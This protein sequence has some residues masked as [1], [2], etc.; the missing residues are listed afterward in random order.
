[1]YTGSEKFW[2]KA[3]NVYEKVMTVFFVIVMLFG[4]YIT[5]DYIYIYKYSEQ[6]VKRFKP[7]VIN[8]DTLRE[9]SGDAV[10]WITLDD[11]PID[12]PIMQTD[13]NVDYLNKDPK[14]KYS[15]G[16]SIFM[17]FR[18]SS[19]FTDRYSLVYGHH[20]AAKRMFG[21][22]DMYKEKDFAESHQ[23]GI[24]YTR[25]KNYRVRVVSYYITKTDCDDI[26]NPDESVDRSY[27]LKSAGLYYLAQNET[28]RLL[29][30]TTCKDPATTDRTAL[31]LAIGEELGEDS[32]GEDRPEVK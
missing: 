8:E 17:D 24:L 22:L 31:L 26:F 13:N 9:I 15:L 29:A 6:A 1:M 18:C 32:L 20:M 11:T 14:G 4:A 21:A 7:D 12:Y 10:G 27:Y 2:D 3:N 30:L 25:K 5:L 23:T 16:G 28:D 19:D